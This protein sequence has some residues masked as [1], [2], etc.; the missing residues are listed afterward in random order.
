V[1]RQ[2]ELYGLAYLLADGKAGTRLHCF[3]AAYEI[4]IQ[5]KPEPRPF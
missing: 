1:R 4:D 3:E 2:P 5:P